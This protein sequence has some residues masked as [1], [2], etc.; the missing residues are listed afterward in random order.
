M[1]R[2]FVAALEYATG[3]R[4]LVLGKPARQFFD[5]AA[6]LVRCPPAEIVMIG[7]DI[8]SDVRGA[9]EAGM[10][11]VLVKTGKFRDADLTTEDTTGR[12]AAFV[13]LPAGLVAHSGDS[14]NEQTETSALTMVGTASTYGFTVVMLGLRGAVRTGW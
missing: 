13:G 6:R 1:H 5:V 10:Q 12:R 3:R 9:Q 11:G 7:D 4:A 14:G 8:T 2:A